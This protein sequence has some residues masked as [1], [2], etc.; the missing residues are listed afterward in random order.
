MAYFFFLLP[1]K[2]WVELSCLQ[3]RN[4]G[5]WRLDSP[6]VFLLILLWKL[7]VLKLHVVWMLSDETEPAELS[8]SWM[9][10]WWAWDWDLATAT[11]QRARGAWRWADFSALSK[12]CVKAPFSVFLADVGMKLRNITLN[13]ISFLCWWIS[14]CSK[15][16]SCSVSDQKVP[17]STQRCV[18]LWL[19]ESL[20]LR[21]CYPLSSFYDRQQS[22]VTPLL[23]Y[24]T[25]L[26]NAS[27]LIEC[28]N[29]NFALKWSL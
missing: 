16:F 3:E 21:K 27:A 12:P 1:N 13:E 11:C 5:Q 10:V 18:V 24:P 22:P 26:M 4:A 8:S 9:L 15:L 25:H 6:S 20:W 23:A 7:K 14:R 17:S 28:N 29:K 2:R 19:N